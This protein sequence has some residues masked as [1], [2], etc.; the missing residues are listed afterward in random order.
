MIRWIGWWGNFQRKDT[1][2]VLTIPL[3]GG[4]YLGLTKVKG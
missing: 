4:L 3:G 2:W 1:G